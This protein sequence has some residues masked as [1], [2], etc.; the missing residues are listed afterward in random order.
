M[1]VISISML[2][3]EEVQGLNLDTKLC[4]EK[5]LMFMFDNPFILKMYHAYVTKENIYFIMPL[6]KAGDFFSLQR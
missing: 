2:A 6:M 1:K 4:L 3:R 5:E